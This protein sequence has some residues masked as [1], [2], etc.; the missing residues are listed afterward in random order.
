M[1]THPTD[2]VTQVIEDLKQHNIL[3]PNNNTVY[4]LPL[5]LVAKTSGAA[6]PV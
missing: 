5:F 2:L 6:C 3:V 4:A 1:K